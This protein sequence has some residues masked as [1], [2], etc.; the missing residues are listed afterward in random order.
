MSESTQSETPEK[1]ETPATGEP[2]AAGGG[3]TP[4]DDVRMTI[5]EHLSELRSRIVRAGV[6]VA[7]GATVCWVY[8]DNILGW[9]VKPY[10]TLWKE[11]FPTIPLELQ[12]LAPAD[13]FVNYMQMAIVGGI[14]VG[15]PVIFYQLWSFIS[16]GLYAREKK[17]VVPFVLFS[18]TLFLSGV[19]FGYFVAFP[20]FFGYFFSLL[21]NIGSGGTLLTSRPT[22]E[23]YL[24]FTEKLLLIFGLIFELPLFIAFLSIAG[25]VTPRQLVKFTR[26]AILLS[27]IAGAVITP[28]SEV[29]SMLVVT[30]ALVGLYILS[31]GLS[32]L[33]AKRRD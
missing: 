2:A 10:E 8:K 11:R 19:S 32:F 30:A 5:W 24:D 31:I 20:F 6:A 16:P 17:Y 12:T 28:G 33:V 9:L 25:L 23:S 14:V 21:G 22:M 3:N 29:T 26:W 18:T 15:V 27:A 7:I 1:P 4:E 13:V